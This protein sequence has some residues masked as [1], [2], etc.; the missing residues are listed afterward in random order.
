MY[1]CT[2][3]LG[4]L[5]SRST[6]ER[7]PTKAKSPSV[8]DVLSSS[9]STVRKHRNAVRSLWAHFP[10]FSFRLGVSPRRYG[11]PRRNA[12]ERLRSVIMRD[13]RCAETI[14]R[15]LDDLNDLLLSRK[16]GDNLEE[17]VRRG[18]W[19]SGLGGTSW[20]YLKTSAVDFPID[21]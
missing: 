19:K 5:R 6:A 9:L 3:L 4:C 11:A 14:Q 2:A 12:Q 1:L 10:L 15:L 7:K 18:P 21:C 20:V 13:E 16:A 8:F 17:K